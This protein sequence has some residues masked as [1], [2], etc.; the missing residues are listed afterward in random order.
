[1]SGTGAAGSAGRALRFVVVAQ[2]APPL[3]ALRALCEAEAE[4][5]LVS[6]HPD[7]R[8]AADVVGVVTPAALVYLLKID[9]EL[10]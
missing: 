10:S 8:R 4:L 5:V 1:V 6:R 3:T 2:Q 7:A 9:E